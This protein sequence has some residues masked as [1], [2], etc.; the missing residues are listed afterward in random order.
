MECVV[1]PLI[2]LCLL[3]FVALQLFIFLM[4]RDDVTW[5]ELV[6]AKLLVL[7]DPEKYLKRNASRTIRLFLRAFA[8]LVIAGWITVWSNNQW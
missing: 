8:S 1:G 5:S 6:R 3:A 7:Y 4:K 2:W